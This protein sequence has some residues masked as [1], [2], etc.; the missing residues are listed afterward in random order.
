MRPSAAALD[1]RL[2]RRSLRSA[3]TADRC[4]RDARTLSAPSELHQVDSRA[5][6]DLVLDRRARLNRRGERL[7]MPCRAAVAGP[8]HG[9]ALPDVALTEDVA[10]GHENE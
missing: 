1:G 7:P 4:G 9:G 10:V 6:P 5:A 3:E 8:E 2:A